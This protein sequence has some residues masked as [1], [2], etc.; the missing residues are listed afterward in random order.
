MKLLES[1]KQLVHDSSKPDLPVGPYNS[2]MR[3]FMCRIMDI[4]ETF[5]GLYENFDLVKEKYFHDFLCDEVD[6]DY[7]Y[8]VE[9]TYGQYYTLKVIDWSYDYEDV[10]KIRV[11]AFL[12]EDNW[13]E[14]VQRQ[15]DYKAIANMEKEIKRINDTITIGPARISELTKQI[16]EIKARYSNDLKS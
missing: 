13:R 7:T 3:Q 9:H 8:S 6:R 5:P 11:P 14:D 1:V 2:I 10:T 16:G 12:L 4:E 15:K